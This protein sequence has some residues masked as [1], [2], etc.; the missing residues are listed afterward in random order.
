MLSQ[1]GVSMSFK[2]PYTTSQNEGFGREKQMHN[3]PA[4]PIPSARGCL[5][6]TEMGG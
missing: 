6:T 4:S 1:D 3:P 5:T 2:N